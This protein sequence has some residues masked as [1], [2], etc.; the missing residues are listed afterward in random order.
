MK[1]YAD[2][3]LEATNPKMEL[4]YETSMPAAPSLRL[5]KHPLALTGGT[6]LL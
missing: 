2:I 4:S 5:F 1:L 3:I 6:K